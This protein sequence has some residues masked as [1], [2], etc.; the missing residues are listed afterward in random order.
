MTGICYICGNNSIL[1]CFL[2]EIRSD[3]SRTDESWKS[4]DGDGE[5]T[6]DCLPIRF[7]GQNKMIGLQGTGSTKSYFRAPRN[8]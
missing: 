5:C 8:L 7:D 6:D 1:Q 3:F 2:V 4:S